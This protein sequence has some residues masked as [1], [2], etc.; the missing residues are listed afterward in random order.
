MEETKPR[1]KFRSITSGRR[2]VRSVRSGPVEQSVSH[3]TTSKL[4]GSV[5]ATAAAAGT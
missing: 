1:T 5:A 2:H 4:S 3:T